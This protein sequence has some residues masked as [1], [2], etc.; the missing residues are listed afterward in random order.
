[1]DMLLFYNTNQIQCMNILLLLLALLEVRH[2]PNPSFLLPSLVTYHC[3]FLFCSVSFCSFTQVSDLSILMKIPSFKFANTNSVSFSY[4][5]NT[6]EEDLRIIRAVSPPIPSGRT[7]RTHVYV[8]WTL[9]FWLDSDFLVY[10]TV[11]SMRAHY[12]GS[13]QLDSLSPILPSFPFMNESFEGDTAECVGEKDTNLSSLKPSKC[14]TIKI[15]LTI[16]WAIDGRL[17][18]LAHQIPQSKDTMIF[19]KRHQLGQCPGSATS[20][21]PP[22]RYLEENID[23][24][25]DLTYRKCRMLFSVLHIQVISSI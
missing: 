20:L 12:T 6:L 11:I 18:R 23:L 14:Q 2:A 8:F 16:H 5:V 22:S 10:I 17:L 19:R 25:L 15:A 24:K 4:T 1:M 7:S 9:Q 13:L 21:P 3:R